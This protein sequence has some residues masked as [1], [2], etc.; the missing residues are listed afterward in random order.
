M[1]ET[2]V[3][4]ESKETPI[5]VV[6]VDVNIAK[7]HVTNISAL[8][9]KV[10]IKEKIEKGKNKTVVTGL[11]LVE[12]LSTEKGLRNFAKKIKTGFG[13]GCHMT[14]DDVSKQNILIFQGNHRNKIKALIKEKYPNICVG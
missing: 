13:C 10:I 3:L 9:K 12:E 11:E 4:N 14:K 5:N 6:D 2:E 7:G 1:F 8:D